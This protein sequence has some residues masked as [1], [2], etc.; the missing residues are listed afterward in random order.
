MGECIGICKYD[1]SNVLRKARK[2]SS[3]A[4]KDFP[5][6]VTEEEAKAFLDSLKWSK[7]KK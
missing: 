2:C 7:I 5:A 4:L 1:S 3:V 6:D